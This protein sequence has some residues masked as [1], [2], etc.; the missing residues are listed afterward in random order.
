MVGHGP[1]LLRSATHPVSHIQRLT[2][3][4]VGDDPAQNTVRGESAHGFHRHD[5]TVLGHREPTTDLTRTRIASLGTVIRVVSRATL[6]RA[7]LGW[8]VALG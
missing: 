1:D 7:T 4:G 5:L 8:L 2:V 6:T 3:V